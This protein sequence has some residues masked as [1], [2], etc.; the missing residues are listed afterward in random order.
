[1]PS[2]WHFLLW[3]QRSLVFFPLK[4]GHKTRKVGILVFRWWKID[5]QEFHCLAKPCKPIQKPGYFGLGKAG[6]L[7]PLWFLQSWCFFGFF[8]TLQKKKRCLG[9]SRKPEKGGTWRLKKA[10]IPKTKSQKTNLGGHWHIGRI[11]NHPIAK[12]FQPKYG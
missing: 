6:G 7:A 9:W 5:P 3:S 8:G 1:M 10:R 11:E 2:N 12:V 4:T